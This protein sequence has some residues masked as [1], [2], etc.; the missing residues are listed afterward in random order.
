M[1]SGDPNNDEQFFDCHDDTIT[2]DAEKSI[3]TKID[4]TYHDTLE[5][6]TPETSSENKNNDNTSRIHF[7]DEDFQR[8][9][10]KDW[11]DEDFVSKNYLFSLLHMYL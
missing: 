9:V 6:L 1:H 11:S 4:P 8:D 3:D 2:V 5:D 7:V 10:Q